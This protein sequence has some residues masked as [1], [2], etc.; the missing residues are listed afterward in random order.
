MVIVSTT[1]KQYQV[2]EEGCHDSDGLWY[3]DL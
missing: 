3:G 1:I 2:Y